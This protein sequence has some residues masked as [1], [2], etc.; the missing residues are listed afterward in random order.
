M[1]EWISVWTSGFEK[2]LVHLTSGS[3]S[4]VKPLHKKTRHSPHVQSLQRE[5]SSFNK[6]T[7]TGPGLHQVEEKY[8]E[9]Y[10]TFKT[11]KEEVPRNNKDLSPSLMPKKTLSQ[12]Q[13]AIPKPLLAKE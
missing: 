10:L 9:S 6:E 3:E 7:L 12:E 2:S 1:D 13:V 11:R 4:L 8:L 5:P